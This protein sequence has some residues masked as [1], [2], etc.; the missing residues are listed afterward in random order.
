M[1]GALKLDPADCV[2]YAKQNSWRGS[3]TPV[4]LPPGAVLFST[5]LSLLVPAFRRLWT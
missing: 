5:G 3:V 2:A 4:P 1:F